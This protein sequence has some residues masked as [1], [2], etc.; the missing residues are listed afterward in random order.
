MNQIEDVCLK[1]LTFLLTFYQNTLYQN[2]QRF[3]FTCGA[4]DIHV[5]LPMKSLE[6][7]GWS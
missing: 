6:W 1:L 7:Y 2:T 4:I 5:H 3:Y